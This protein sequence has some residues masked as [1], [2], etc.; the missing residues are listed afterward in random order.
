MSIRSIDLVHPELFAARAE[1]RRLPGR[2]RLSFA[3]R[4]ARKRACRYL[5]DCGDWLDNRDAERALAAIEADE[6]RFW[7]EARRWIW[8][9]MGVLV[10]AFWIF[11]GIPAV[12][13][14]IRWGGELLGRVL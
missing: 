7:R 14:A 6:A 11:L 13:H 4:E 8:G 1:V 3:D 2:G 9:G 12:A 10:A 5:M